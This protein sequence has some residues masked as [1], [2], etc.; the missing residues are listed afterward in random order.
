MGT[1]T[2]LELFS[3]SI[4]PQKDIVY[5]KYYGSKQ[6]NRIN[7]NRYLWNIHLRVCAT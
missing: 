6:E 3:L 4:H 2:D 5:W 1:N 7:F